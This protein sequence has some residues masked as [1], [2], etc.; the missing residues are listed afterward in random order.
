MRVLLI[1][2]PYPSTFWSFKR[3]AQMLGKKSVLPPLGL[4]TVAALFPEGT[5]FTLVDM[6]VQELAENDWENHDV[7]MI[8]GMQIQQSGI[9]MAIRE[10]KRRAKKVVVGGPWA[11][12][13]YDRALESGADIVVRGELESSIQDLL[14]ALSENKSGIVINSGIPELNTS[15]I[16]RYDLLDLKRYMDMAVQFSR[17]CPFKCEF[18]DITLMFGRTVRTK[19]P[20]QVIGE[21]DVLYN[22]GWRG[23]IFFVDD[24]FI[25]RM[26]SAKTFLRLLI[27]WQSDHGYPFEFYTQASVNLAADDELLDLMVRAGFCFVFLGIE[28]LDTDSLYNVGKFQNLAIDLDAACQ[29]INRAGLQV[30]AGCIIGFDN[31]A[32]GADQRLIA[33]AVR[34]Q[35]PEVF[36]TMLQAMPGTDLWNRVKE[37]GRLFCTGQDNLISQTGRVNFATTRP[38]QEIT[39]EFINLYHDLYEPKNYLSRVYGHLVKMPKPS[40]KTNAAFKWNEV[41]GLLYLIARQGFMYESRK[42]FWKYLLSTLINMPWKL[43]SFFV[44]CFRAEHYY[45]FRTIVEKELMQTIDKSP[46]EQ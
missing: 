38:L 22:L 19:S 30:I 31:E 21:L 46:L 13:F 40:V 20:P 15:P 39:A 33:F 10:G 36:A 44:Y 16:P 27:A 4:L 12:H 24:N 14:A 2:P 17:G 43:R 18:C 25:G 28:T 37:E 29:K 3:V 41:I 9:L 5:S 11:F 26:V 23:A 32:P 42:Y 45:H 35:I 8:S 7:V 6:A 34:N 1:N